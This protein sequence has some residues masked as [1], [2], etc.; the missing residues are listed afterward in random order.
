VSKSFEAASV[1]NARLLLDEVDENKL[2]CEEVVV[3]VSNVGDEQVHFSCTNSGCD[4]SVNELDCDDS[5]FT[6]I[7]SGEAVLSSSVVFDGQI[8][9]VS[10]IECV[11]SDCITIDNASEFSD[12]FHDDVKFDC[13]GLSCRQNSDSCEL[14]DCD[15]L[16][17]IIDVKFDCVGLSCRQNSDSCELSDCDI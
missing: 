1:D 10:N 3:S 15:S 9:N 5:Q 2:L 6:D 12:A 17:H 16:V 4:S 11:L 14:S 13:V 8:V 7:A